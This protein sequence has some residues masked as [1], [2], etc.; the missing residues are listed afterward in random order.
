MLIRL[1]L[2]SNK[3]NDDTKTFQL[4]Y[5]SQEDPLIHHEL[6]QD[7]TL[8]Q[9]S[10]SPPT[11]PL[12]TA[13]SAGPPRKK[14]LHIAD[15]EDHIDYEN[16][17][18][19]EGEAA[20][21]GIYYDDSNY[22]YMQHLRDI[23]D[24]TSEARLLDTLPAAL[25]GKEQGKGKRKLMGLEE[26]LQ[27]ASLGHDTEQDDALE[28]QDAVGSLD[29]ELSRFS[30]TARQRTY[31]DMQDVPD[32]IAGFQ[33]GMDPRLREALEA[34]DDE[35]FI[36]GDEGG[37]DDEDDI[38]GKLVQGGTDAQLDLDE[39]EAM[40]AEEN[41]TGWESDITEK[42][43]DQDG[44]KTQH[45]TRSLQAAP[46]DLADVSG[47]EAEAAAA[48]DGDWLRDF[49]KFKRNQK[50]VGSAQL[51]RETSDSFIV[52]RPQNQKQSQSMPHPPPPSTLYTQ[53]GT[54]HRRLKRR[55]GALTD[56][57][58]FSMT[59]SSLQRTD[60][61]RLLDDRFD[62]IQ[63]KYTLDSLEDCDEDNWDKNDDD[64]VSTLSGSSKRSRYSKMSTRSRASV[65]TTKSGFVDRPVR[66]DLD[67]IM[68]G[69]LND[70]AER[71]SMRVSGASSGGGSTGAYCGKRKGKPAKRGKNGNEI[72]GIKMLDEVRQGLGP[73]RLKAQKA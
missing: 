22:D 27:Q 73:A 38:F 58:N 66:S 34:L 56:P 53:N 28:S 48:E 57:S 21:Y 60:A 37:P 65:A 6:A 70:W 15:L 31:Q 40:A 32:E 3:N 26:A 20:N 14:S 19:N 24:S 68:D 42:A 59:S 29:D 23:G 5:R 54:P 49:A 47:A 62:Q 36:A 35:A 33:P 71:N 2:R 17:R 52:Q 41:N 72:A 69:F 61:Q 9:T 50:T 8:Y 11:K 10:G 63:A 4:V 16:V 64:A 25:R 46:L 43:I 44:L 55:P 51:T 7:R 1:N 18:E 67:N 12:T 13:E 39:F 30:S 45:L